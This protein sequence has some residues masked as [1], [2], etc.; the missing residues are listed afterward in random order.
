LRLKKWWIKKI[1]ETPTKPIVAQVTQLNDELVVA[2]GVVEAGEAG[3]AVPLAKLSLP[4]IVLESPSEDSPA[5]VPLLVDPV[6]LL[7]KFQLK[8]KVG[9]VPVCVVGLGD[10]GPAIGILFFSPQK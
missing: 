3:A 4:V 8:G 9:P 6:L 10:N 2:A 7:P 1:A 5:S